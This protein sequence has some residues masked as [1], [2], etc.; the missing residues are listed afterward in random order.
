MLRRAIVFLVITLLFGVSTTKADI[1]WDVTSISNIDVF[2]QGNTYFHITD[3][4]QVGTSITGGSL[5]HPGFP[6][7]I[8]SGSVI[9]N[10]IDVMAHYR[11]FPS[12]TMTLEGTIALDGSMSGTWLDTWANSDRTGTWEST[13]GSAVRVPVPGAFL[14]GSMGLGFAALRLKRRRTA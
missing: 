2:Y 10:E 6:K 8:D 13:T 11:D 9:G 14:L 12:V 5:V 1:M 7:D 3:L 4:V